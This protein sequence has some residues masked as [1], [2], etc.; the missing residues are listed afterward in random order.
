MVAIFPEF[1]NVTSLVNVGSAPPI[2]VQ[3]L[4]GEGLRVTWEID[5]S[6]SSEPDSGRVTIYNLQTASRRILSA[7]IP[8]L[9]GFAFR[10]SLSIGWG[11]VQNP[12][13][14]FVPPTQVLTG[15]IVSIVPERKERVDVLTEIRFGDGTVEQRDT[16][17]NGTALRSA[18]LL[19]WSSIIRLVVLELG[20]TLSPAADLVIDQAA[21]N[22][23]LPSYGAANAIIGDRE[24]REKLDNLFDTLRLG[25]TIDN[26]VVRV[27]DSSGLRNDLPPQRLTPLSGLLSFAVT[28]DGGVEF[29]ALAN[30]LVAPGSQ[31]TIENA[32]QIVQGGGPLRVERIRFVGDNY[33]ESIMRG[34]ARKFVPL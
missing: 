1:L 12:G 2:T 25:Y 27:F 32:A 4:T 30:P 14:G 17:P 24:V 3:N 31:V 34:V 16:A 13:L 11:D 21:S 18:Q 9:P 22:L 5:K 29:E 15:Q 19:T 6:N 28:D 33:R 26:G 20:F 10:C 23:N 8:S 7:L